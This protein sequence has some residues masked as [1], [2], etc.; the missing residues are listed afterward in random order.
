MTLI[1]SNNIS[2]PGISISLGQLLTDK[3]TIRLTFDK[4]GALSNEMQ[5]DAYNEFKC[6]GKSGIH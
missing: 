6:G 3:A 4:S 1:E 2:K 5:F